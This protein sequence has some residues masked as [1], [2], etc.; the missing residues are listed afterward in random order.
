MVFANTA[1]VSICQSAASATCGSPRQA[2]SQPNCKQRQPPGFGPS[3][4]PHSAGMGRWYCKP[5]LRSGVEGCSTPT[6]ASICRRLPVFF[7]RQREMG[8]TRCSARLGY[9]CVVWMSYRSASRTLGQRRTLVGHQRRQAHRIASRLGRRRA[10][11]GP[12]EP[13]PS[14]PVSGSGQRH[15]AL[16]GRVPPTVVGNRF[17][18]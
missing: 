13:G 9:L 6:V 2:S 7:A 5:R 3:R 10:C 11:G 4:P 16:D 8:R 15:L 12:I 1:V 17:H 14:S 18:R